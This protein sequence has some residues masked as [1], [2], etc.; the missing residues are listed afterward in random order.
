MS[1][2]HSYDITEIIQ[3]PIRAGSEAYLKWSNTGT[4]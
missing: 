1:R 4:A 3:A 2:S